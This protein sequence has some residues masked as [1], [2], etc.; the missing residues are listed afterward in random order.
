VL[1]YLTAKVEISAEVKRC[2]VRSFSV[3]KLKKTG[4]EEIPSFAVKTGQ[5][6]RAALLPFA[7]AH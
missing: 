7:A 3:E 6:G 5:T 4:N 1:Q 2:A